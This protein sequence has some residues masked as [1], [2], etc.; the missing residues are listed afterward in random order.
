MPGGRAI[1]LA[2]LAGIAVQS[3]GSTASFPGQQRDKRASDLLVAFCHRRSSALALLHT[4]PGRL[5]AAAAAFHLL[6]PN[7]FT[8]EV[9]T[10]VE[11]GGG[12]PQA[13]N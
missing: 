9:S 6:V 10:F 4:P 1:L 13:S 7:Q 3:A 5:K 12:N 2:D 11:E 8:K